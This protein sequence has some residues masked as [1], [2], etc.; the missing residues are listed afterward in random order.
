MLPIRSLPSVQSLH[1]LQ[2]PRFFPAVDAAVTSGKPSLTSSGSGASSGIQGGQQRPLHTPQSDWEAS[3]SYTLLTHL[4]QGT[5]GTPLSTH[6]AVY[7]GLAVYA[8][9]LLINETQ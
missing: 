5:E 7:E 2:V 6:S 3:T 8:G 9:D 1:A 4:V